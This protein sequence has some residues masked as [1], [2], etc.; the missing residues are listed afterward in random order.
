MF[1]NRKPGWFGAQLNKYIPLLQSGD[2]SA[3]SWIFCAFT[4]NHALSKIIAVK[5]LS[6]ALVRLTFNEL[7]RI[8]EQ[9]RQT[10]SMEW[11]INWRNYSIDSFFTSTMNEDERRAVIVFASFNPNGFIRE[12]AVRMMKDYAGTLQFAILRQNDWVSQVRKAADE[13][14]D[15]RLANLSERELISAL[16]FADKFSRSGR[17]KC[18]DTYINRIY[19]VLTSRENERELIAGLGAENIRIRHIC[20]NAL[21]NPENPKFDLAFSQLQHETDPF[22]RASIFRRLMSVGQNM[23]D[24]AERFLRDKYPINRIQAFQYICGNN[25]NRALQI[26][27]DLLLDK[28]VAVREHVRFYLKRNCPDFDYRAFYKNHLTDFT[29][30]AI[31]GLGETGRGEDTTVIEKYLN[32]NQIAVVRAAITA[33]MRL[34]GEKYAAAIIEFLA[35]DRIGIVKTARNLIIKSGCSDYKRVMDIFR[36]TPYENTKQKCFSTL[37]TASK[38]QRLIFILDVLETGGKEI[39]ES[40]MAALERWILSYNHSFVMANKAQTEQISDSIKRL[41]SKLPERMK[42]QLLFLLQ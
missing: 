18:N 38:W 9:M 35:D 23:D 7:V 12:R 11:S 8:D 27:N 30:A 24:A 1:W 26:V 33:L 31:Y 34:S 4:E 13:T 14:V 2:Y 6:T 20:T 10:T 15:Y 40:A 41:R 29:V 32:D 37:L 19:S 25:Q 28:S 21:F 16:P 17:S 3:V 39:M 5:A 36:S 22:L 42:S